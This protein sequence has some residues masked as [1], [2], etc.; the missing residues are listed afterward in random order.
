MIGFLVLLAVLAWALTSAVIAYLIGRGIEQRAMRAFVTLILASVIFALPISDEVVGK[1][2]FDRLCDEAENVKVSGTR[3]VGQELYTSDGRWRL[4]I[5]PSSLE[6]LKQAEKNYQSI[7]RKESTGPVEIGT[8]IPI[9]MYEHRIYDRQKGKVLASYRSYA[10]SGGWLSRYAFEK[11]ILVRNQCFP[12]EARG[13]LNRR[14]LP[15]K[16]RRE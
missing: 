10:T 9:R 1:F 11:P 4:A 2:Q 12:S 6:E 16:A 15:Y 8:T 13:N 14:I 5:R 3:P 7:V